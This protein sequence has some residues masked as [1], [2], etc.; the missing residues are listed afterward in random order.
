MGVWLS[1]LIPGGNEAGASAAGR[2]AR[3]P[4]ILV[5]IAAAMPLALFAGWVVFLNAQQQRRDSQAA[6]V[7][8]L[9]NV[10][11]RLASEI[12][13]QLEIAETVAA[14]ATLDKPDLDAFYREAARVNEAR[15]L[16][17]TIQLVDPD[18]NQVLDVTRPLGEGMRATADREN[19]EQIL[20]TRKPAIGGIGP[21]GRVTGKRV[22]RLVLTQ[23]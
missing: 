12:G 18:G 22:N 2:A 20:K 15:P 3:R 21:R 4:L 19:F 5:F 6:A 14:S 16:W 9:D 17:Q 8:T 23:D 7:E 13:L 1:H 10:V 11:S